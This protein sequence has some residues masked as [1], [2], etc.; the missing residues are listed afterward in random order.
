[1]VVARAVPTCACPSDHLSDAVRFAD[2][3]RLDRAQALE[4]IGQ[5]ATAVGQWR[6]LAEGMGIDSGEIAL[7]RRAF[8]NPDAAQ[9]ARLVA[10]AGRP[11]APA[12]R[13]AA[14]GRARVPA[15][16]RTGGQLTSRARGESD[17]QPGEAGRSRTDAAAGQPALSSSASM[18]RMPLG[19]RR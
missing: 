15:G 1:V 17:A 16:V 2:A 19:P 5:V 7:M 13:P 4:Q 14:G 11:S 12:P 8:D 10:D 3:F 18:T 6:D 9:A